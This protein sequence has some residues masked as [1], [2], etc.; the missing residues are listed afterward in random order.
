[1]LGQPSTGDT[2]AF[3]PRSPSSGT[4]PYLIIGNVLGICAAV[5]QSLQN[6][7]LTIAALG[8]DKQAKALDIRFDL[9]GSPWP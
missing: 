3:R 2:S 5:I 6:V 8:R 1:M 4:V 9:P 7:N